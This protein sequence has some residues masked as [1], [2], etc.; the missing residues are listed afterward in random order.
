MKGA[1]EI[2]FTIVSISL[3]LI[4]VFIPLLLMGGIVGRLFREFA[5]TVSVAVLLSAF[6]SLTLTPMMCSRFLKRQSDQHGWLYRIVEA[7]FDD[8]LAFYRRTLEIA[9]RFRFITLLVFLATRRADRRAVHHHPERLLPDAGHRPDRRG[10]R[11][12]AGRIVRTRCCSCRSSSTT[13]SSTTPRSR[14]SPRRSAPAPPG[15]RATTDASTSTSS[16]GANGRTTA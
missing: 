15:S 3:S 11:R 12:A 7:G 10:I 16:R 6:V 8:I 2:G 14:R 13:S 4:A 9:L 1:G 5:M